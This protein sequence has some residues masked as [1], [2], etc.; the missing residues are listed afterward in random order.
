MSTVRI[1]GSAP[2]PFAGLRGH[3]Y[4][5]ARGLTPRVGAMK[6][7]DT[8]DCPCTPCVQARLLPAVLSICNAHERRRIAQIEQPRWNDPDDESV[9]GLLDAPTI[10]RA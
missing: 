2:D 8:E 9:L 5:A 10:T 4:I 1:R 6:A 3:D 7:P